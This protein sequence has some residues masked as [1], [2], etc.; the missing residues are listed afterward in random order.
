MNR[1]LDDG[2]FQGRSHDRPQEVPTA[3]RSVAQAEDDMQMKAWL[4]FVALGN[5]TDGDEHLALLFDGDLAIALGVQIEPS[6]GGTLEGT[7][8]CHG[9]AAQILLRRKG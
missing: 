6:D 8:G 3:C 2:Q 4:A 9:S 7:Q 1:C 5:V